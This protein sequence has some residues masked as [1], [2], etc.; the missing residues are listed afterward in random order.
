MILNKEEVEQCTKERLLSST[1]GQMEK[2]SKFT[3]ASH[4]MRVGSKT[5]C[6]MEWEEVLPALVKSIKVDL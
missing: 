5:V 1:K 6:A 2:V 4:S 3:K